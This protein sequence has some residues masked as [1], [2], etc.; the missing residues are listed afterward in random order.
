MLHCLHLD[1]ALDA[2]L[3]VS[4]NKAGNQPGKYRLAEVSGFI[5]CRSHDAPGVK[6]S[7]RLAEIY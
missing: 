1:P 6:S 3:S 5:A 4:K 2:I 7:M